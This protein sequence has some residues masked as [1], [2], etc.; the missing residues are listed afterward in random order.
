MIN[1]PSAGKNSCFT[2]SDNNNDDFSIN[3]GLLTIDSVK[4][5]LKEMFKEN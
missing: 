5:I 1:R 3:N 4:E 2:V